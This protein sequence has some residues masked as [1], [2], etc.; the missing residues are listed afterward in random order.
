MSEPIQTVADVVAIIDGDLDCLLARPMMYAQSADAFEL[1]LWWS[2]T[3]RG[4]IL[5]STAEMRAVERELLKERTGRRLGNLP[6]GHH[7]RQEYGQDVY[8]DRTHPKHAAYLD[9]HTEL[10]RRVGAAQNESKP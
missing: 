8:T 6:S 7:L 3:L 9:F 10:A 1:L 2:L 5:R 4:R